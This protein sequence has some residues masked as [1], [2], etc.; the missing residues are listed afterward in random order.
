MESLFE[1]RFFLPDF[2]DQP[3]RERVRVTGT[4]TRELARAAFSARSLAILD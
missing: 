2:H 1:T 4:Q 3:S